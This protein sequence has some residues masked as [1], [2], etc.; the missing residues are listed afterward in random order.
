MSARD[1]R[2]PEGP[3][4]GD[5]A[6]LDART[7]A[8][9]APLRRVGTAAE[10][11]LALTVAGERYALAARAVRAVAELRR[12]TPLP[13]AP[14]HVAG[15]TA[16]SGHVV[17][18]FHLRVMLGLSLAAL[19]EYGR[20]VFLGDGADTFG[21]VV[22]AV[23]DAGALVEVPG[24]AALASSHAPRPLVRAMTP[25]GVAV[26][27]AAALCASELTTVRIAAPTGAP[28]EPTSEE[29]R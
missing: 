5:V 13:H 9:A 19:P 11:C 20:V 10:P 29:T 15:V 26:L 25:D 2:S 16:W 1:D 27:D 14:E 7:R 18:V 22:D 24:E 21:V 12:L 17:P 23:H 3:F 6:R 28:N 8:V 4:G